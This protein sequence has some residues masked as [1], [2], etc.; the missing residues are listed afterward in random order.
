MTGETR[1]R[2]LSLVF[3]RTFALMRLSTALVVLAASPDR[4]GRGRGGMRPRG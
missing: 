2:S 1:S 3:R 4:L